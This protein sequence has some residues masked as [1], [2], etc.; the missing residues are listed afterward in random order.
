MDVEEGR[1]NIKRAAKSGGVISQKWEYRFFGGLYPGHTHAVVEFLIGCQ[2]PDGIS[3]L[4]VPRTMSQYLKYEGSHVQREYFT[5]IALGGAYQYALNPNSYL[6]KEDVTFGQSLRLQ[7]QWQPYWDRNSFMLLEGSH[8]NI[9]RSL[10]LQGLFPGSSKFVFITCHPIEYMYRMVDFLNDE[11]LPTCL[12][13]H[14]LSKK[15]LYEQI[16]KQWSFI[17]NQLEKDYKTLKHVLVVSNEDLR[18]GSG[19]KE[20]ATFVGVNA[21]PPPNLEMFD[22]NARWAA[23]PKEIQVQIAK[24]LQE[25]VVKFGYDFTS[26]TCSRKWDCKNTPQVM[27]PSVMP[28][29]GY[30]FAKIFGTGGGSGFNFKDD[31]FPNGFMLVGFGN[32]ADLYA[33]EQ[34]GEELKSVRNRD[35]HYLSNRE[36]GKKSLVLEMSEP[37][38][39]P[40]MWLFE[41]FSKNFKLYKKQ[42]EDYLKSHKEIG[43]IMFSDLPYFRPIFEAE[44]IPCLYLRSCPSANA[45]KTV[46]G[47]EMARMKEME[48]AGFATLPKESGLCTAEAIDFFRDLK[49]RFTF[50]PVPNKHHHATG[51]LDQPSGWFL[52]TYEN[53]PHELPE[54]IQ[55]FLFGKKP[56]FISFGYASLDDPVVQGILRTLRQKNHSLLFFGKSFSKTESDNEL[57]LSDPNLLTIVLPKCAFAV[58]CG[59]FISSMRALQARIKSLVIPFSKIM[60]HQ[61]W[62]DFIVEKKEGLVYDGPPSLDA[63]FKESKK[64]RM[65]TSI[66]TERGGAHTAGMTIANFFKDEKAK[67]RR[68][69]AEQLFEKSTNLAQLSYL[70]SRPESAKTPPMETYPLVDEV[71]QVL[72][73]EG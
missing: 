8:S 64:I 7:E 12:R 25:D 9:M 10:F 50:V 23:E 36:I 42:L 63:M 59:D 31:P 16:I 70:I 37:T 21:S 38:L 54:D 47:S 66:V 53:T 52:P 2:H 41:N 30:N 14:R 13:K 45:V 61:S 27:K 71:L 3:A 43:C 62:G 19:F 65:D 73:R 32:E 24:L 46:I 49:T 69:E 6:T 15:E 68:E 60:G 57:F 28:P 33:L 26:L 5:D 56:V 67:T 51:L 4:T 17:H 72:E 48:E 39:D 40:A 20:I 29:G 35:V 22:I 34:I 58:H 55:T 18:S 1:A 44:N 11:S